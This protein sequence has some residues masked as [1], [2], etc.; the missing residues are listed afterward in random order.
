MIPGLERTTSYKNFLI[1]L[2]VLGGL[3]YNGENI[4]YG[5][6]EA[7]DKK[8]AIGCL[9]PYVQFFISLYCSI[10]S[11]FWTTQTL[12]FVLMSSSFL[13]YAN[14]ILNFNSTASMRFNWFFFEPFVFLGIIAA[15]NQNVVSD[16][17]AIMLYS[18][19]MMWISINYLIFMSSLINEITSIMGLRFLLNKPK[20]SQKKLK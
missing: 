4:F 5:I 3:H 15:D 17:Q 8:Y 9:L 19:F 16:T 11:R 20:T 10:Y 14:G 18:A 7:K 1:I 2:G 6:M 13:L 12:L